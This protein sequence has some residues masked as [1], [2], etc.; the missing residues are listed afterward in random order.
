MKS[1]VS[2]I[3]RMSFLCAGTVLAF[4]A[5]TVAPDAHERAQQVV[6]GTMQDACDRMAGSPY[7]QS[8][9]PAYAPVGLDSIAPDAVTA[10]KVA[11]EASGNPR[12]AFQ[13]GRALNRTDAADQ[14]MAAYETAANADY[15]AAKVNLGMLL[16]RLGDSNREFEMYRQAAEAGNTLAAY[17]LG[18]AYRDG[19]GT[20]RDGKQALHWFETAAAAGDS[21]AAF[22]I[23]SM[24]DEGEL[25][26]EDNQMA[27]AWYDLA[28]K[29]GNAD[30][31]INLGLMYETGEGIPVNREAAA[32]LYAQAAATGD[33]FG[34]LKL[35]ELQQAGV[36]LPEQHPAPAVTEN[37]GID[38]LVLQEG[39]V[40]V[41]SSLIEI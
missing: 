21:T 2:R 19:I 38:T 40:A 36:T 8:R 4:G 17:N 27:I 26:A 14:A 5:F 28:A 33:T 39:D 22:N 23:G 35:Q 11:F 13:L 6:A 31:M 20:E 37:G 7:D 3:S 12:F 9:N 15:A 34:A 29:R 32:R 30:A 25:V 16:G 18:V 41:P 10:C 24:Y 1:R